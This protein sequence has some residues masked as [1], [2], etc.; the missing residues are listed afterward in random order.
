[1]CFGIEYCELCGGELELI[2]KYGDGWT[3]PKEKVYICPVCGCKYTWRQDTGWEYDDSNVDWSI[4][5]DE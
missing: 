1:M 3:E 4:V 5:Y 2:G